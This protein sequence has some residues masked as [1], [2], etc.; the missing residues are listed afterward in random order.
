M[1]LK[2]EVGEGLVTT[3]FG[4]IDKIAGEGI[5][6]KLVSEVAVWPLA[7]I[8]IGPVLALMGTVVTMLEAVADRTVAAVPLK[9]TVL[10]AA[11]GL[12]P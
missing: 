2:I 9:E 1:K 5:K 4:L 6:T 7:V 12:K 10:R 11:V 8:V 3:T